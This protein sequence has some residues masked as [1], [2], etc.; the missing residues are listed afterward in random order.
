MCVCGGA[1][2]TRSPKNTS[3][4]FKG[5]RSRSVSSHSHRLSPRRP[6]G[7]ER[8]AGGEYH[9]EASITWI[10]LHRSRENTAKLNN[11][12]PIACWHNVLSHTLSH[13]HALTLV[14]NFSNQRS[15]P[16][17]PS[18]ANRRLAPRDSLAARIA[19]ASYD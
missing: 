5:A 17:A 11:T 9:T 18:P 2:L 13:T 4:A 1:A 8:G 15:V 3:L 16:V 6:R 10:S 12:L 14:E 19:S 7:E